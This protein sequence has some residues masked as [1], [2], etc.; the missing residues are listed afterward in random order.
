[1]PLPSLLLAHAALAM[2]CEFANYSGRASPLPGAMSVNLAECERAALEQRA[3]MVGVSE[4]KRREHGVLRADM[5]G[6]V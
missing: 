3:D 4:E 6:S 1:M 5:K 2:A